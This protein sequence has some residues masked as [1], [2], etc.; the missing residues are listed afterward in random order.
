MK[1]PVNAVYRRRLLTHRIGMALSIFAMAI[2]LFVLLAAGSLL[3]TANRA[4]AAQAH[5]AALEDGGRFALDLIGRALRQAAY[6]DWD[7]DAGPDDTAPARLAGLD[8]KTVSKS[9]HGIA[10]PLPVEVNGSEV[11][12][13]RFSGAGPGQ[14]GDGSVTSCAGFSVGAGDEGWSVFYVARNAQ[15]EPELRCKYRGASGWNADAVV[16]GVDGFQVLY[17]VDTDSPPDGVPNRYVNASAIDALDA[18]LVPEGAT[19]TA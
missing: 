18:D 2:G 17:G 4:F 10:D 7:L 11:L 1:A 9:G 16:S 12:A 19:E 8:S 6:V 3:V 13:L 14:H 5:A 15:G